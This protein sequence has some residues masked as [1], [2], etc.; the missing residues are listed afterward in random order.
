[1]REVVVVS[2]VRTPLGKFQGSLQ[3]FAAPRLGALAGPRA[4][5]AYAVSGCIYVLYEDEGALRNIG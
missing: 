4:G 2:A 5:Q 3:S 1:M